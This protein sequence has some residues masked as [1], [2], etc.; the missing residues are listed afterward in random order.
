MTPTPDITA[1]ARAAVVA[2]VAREKYIAEALGAP[3]RLVYGAR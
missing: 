2:R 1:L 3:A